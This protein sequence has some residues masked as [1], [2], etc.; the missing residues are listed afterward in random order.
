MSRGWGRHGVGD[1]RGSDQLCGL[2]LGRGSVSSGGNTGRNSSLGVW[3]GQA[4][5]ET[6]IVS[7]QHHSS[8]QSCSHKTS[9]CMER[10]EVILSG[11]QE[12]PPSRMS[13]VRQ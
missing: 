11:S 13:R 8:N 3:W 2:V 6:D 7:M 12:H 9:C 1:L 5:K 4:Q 10:A